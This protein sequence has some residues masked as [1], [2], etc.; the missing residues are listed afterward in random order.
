MEKLNLK[1]LVLLVSLSCLF[2]INMKAQDATKPAADTSSTV[3]GQPI[4]DTSI[5]FHMDAPI[6]RLDM[7]GVIVT[8][9]LQQENS[10]IRMAL[11]IENT[12][13]EVPKN[14]ATEIKKSAKPN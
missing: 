9:T 14:N 13:S 11:P 6:T 2:S 7:I 12:I 8:D 1:T 5:F 3:I 4:P 10:G